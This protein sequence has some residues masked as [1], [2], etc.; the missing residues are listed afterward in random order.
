MRKKKLPL[1]IEILL[2]LSKIK[3]ELQRNERHMAAQKASEL[4]GLLAS[5][6]AMRRRARRWNL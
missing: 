3:E 5:G 6:S 4:M 1:Q 2:I